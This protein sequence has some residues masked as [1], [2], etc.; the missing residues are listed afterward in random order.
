MSIAFPIPTM[1]QD[2]Y[3]TSGLR[4]IAYDVDTQTYTFIDSKGRQYR[5]VPGTEY[6]IAGRVTEK[7]VA[8]E[9]PGAFSG[10]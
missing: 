8:T 4:L 7:D 10:E 5:G 6:E 9:R 2:Y 3:R 1:Q